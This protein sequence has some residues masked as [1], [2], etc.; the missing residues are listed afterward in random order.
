MAVGKY[1]DDAK[2]FTLQNI[3]LQKGDIIYT[4]TDGY[5][6]Q[7]GGDKGKKFFSKKLKELLIENCH[8]TMPE[9]KEKL[10]KIINN[11]KGNAEQVD[12]ILVIGVRI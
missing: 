1:S 5:A 3:D 2:D 8:L 6:D 10:A 9:Q 12:D 7:F 4:F 11:W